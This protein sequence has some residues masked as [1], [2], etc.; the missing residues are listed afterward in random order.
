MA[1]ERTVAVVPSAG[2]GERMGCGGNKVFLPLGD[3]PV[4][5]HTLAVFEECPLVDEVVVAVGQGEEDTCRHEVVEPFGLRKVTGLVRGG[6][7]RQESVGLALR[8]IGSSADVI[9]VHDG[10]R[11]L[12]PVSLLTRAVLAGRRHGAVVVGL[13]VKDTVKRVGA[14][15]PATAT[16]AAVESAPPTGTAVGAAPPRAG[17]SSG[18]PGSGGGP[19]PRNVGEGEAE[20]PSFRVLETVERSRLWQVETP[21]VFWRDLLVMAHKRAADAGFLATD[22]AALVERLRHPVLIIPGSEENIKVTTPLDMVLARAILED[23]VKRRR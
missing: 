2:R 4:L 3:R 1:A 22:D 5:A 16:G 20:T 18:Q 8:F 7:S 12:L 6:A 17:G 10:A 14:A 19:G 13:P 23:R 21:Q 11:P 9:V 15:G